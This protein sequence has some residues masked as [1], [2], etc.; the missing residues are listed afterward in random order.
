MGALSTAGPSLQE[1]FMLMPQRPALFES[2]RSALL[3]RRGPEGRN[4]AGRIPAGRLAPEP[5]G[6]SISNPGSDL[7]GQG[8]QHSDSPRRR[9]AD[10]HPRRPLL[11]YD[12]EADQFHYVWPTE[13]D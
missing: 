8:T 9:R 6:P 3:L 7:R 11:T 2:S 12:Q 13:R 1:R 5:K 10:T 4:P